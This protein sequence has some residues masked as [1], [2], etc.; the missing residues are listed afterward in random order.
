MITFFWFVHNNKERVVTLL[1]FFVVRPVK[2]L[3]LICC[4]QIC[5]LRPYKT[6]LKYKARSSFNRIFNRLHH[7]RKKFCSNFYGPFLLWL[8]RFLDMSCPRK[9]LTHPWK[10]VLNMESL[11]MVSNSVYDVAALR[12]KVTK[13]MAKK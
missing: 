1:G 5:Y 10:A 11:V 6:V 13:K 7:N 2:S 9:S 4:A 8:S 12:E 3:F